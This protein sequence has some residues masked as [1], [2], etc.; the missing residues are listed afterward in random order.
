MMRLNPEH[1]LIKIGSHYMIVDACAEGA[2]LTNVYEL[3]P[4]AAWLWE[5]LGHREFSRESL[6][7]ML[8]GE[9]D[10]SEE[11][12]GEDVDRLLGVWKRYALIIG[13]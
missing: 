5:Q 11:Q 8:C 10:V 3:N 1:R 7:G 13:G 4:S 9:Y 12:A 6:I 2:N